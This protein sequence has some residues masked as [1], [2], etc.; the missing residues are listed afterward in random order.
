MKSVLDVFASG[1]RGPEHP[2]HLG[3]VK[4]NVGHAGSGSGVTSLIKV[5]MMMEETKYRH[6]VAS[7]QRLIATSLLTLKHGM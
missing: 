2:L 5:L 6:I 7:K 1:E 4:A 3:S